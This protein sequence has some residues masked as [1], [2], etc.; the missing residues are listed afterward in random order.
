MAAGD[1]TLRS[2]NVFR[3]SW[4]QS[5]MQTWIRR[6]YTSHVAHLTVFMSSGC[7]LYME[8]R[9]LQPANKFIRHEPYHALVLIAGFVTI[10]IIMT[11][12]LTQ[13][14]L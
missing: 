14:V 2:W 3:N 8:F 12:R 10:I 5:Q 11:E 6:L 13:D 9:L 1:E 7:N 4:P